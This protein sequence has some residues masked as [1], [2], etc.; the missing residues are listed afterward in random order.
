MRGGMGR[1]WGC[2]VL[3]GSSGGLAGS[4][5][6]RQEV[7]SSHLVYHPP[8]TEEAHGVPA[9][10]QITDTRLLAACLPGSGADVSM[11]SMGVG[12]AVGGPPASRCWLPGAGWV[13]GRRPHTSHTA[14]RTDEQGRSR[15]TSSPHS[16]HHLLGMKY[17]V[18]HC[19][20]LPLIIYFSLHLNTTSRKGQY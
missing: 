19:G 12:A 1:G 17:I 5:C 20:V 4:S 3:G 18:M 14:S 11:T 13:V 16:V 8:V 10:M 6:G 9:F 7:R 2:R 15:T